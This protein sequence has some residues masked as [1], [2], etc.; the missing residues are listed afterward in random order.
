MSQ[1]MSGIARSSVLVDL[2]ISMY[3][4]RKQDTTTRDEVTASKGAKSKRAASVYKSLFADCKELDDII[5]FQAR[6][7][8]THYKY[9]K[10]WLDSGVRM[11]PATLLQLYQD[12]MY[13][14]EREFDELVSKFLDKYDTLVAAAAFQLGTLFNRSEYPLRSEVRRKFAFHLTYTPMPT[15]G[16]FRLDIENE[17]QAALVEQYEKSMQAMAERAAR[18]SWEKLHEVLSRMARQLA[19]REDGKS[20]KIYDSLLGNAYELCELLKHFNVTGDA[21]M[22]NMR[23]QLMG[24]ME[25]LNTDA[26]RKEADTRAIV[27]KKVQAML[28]QHNW[29]IEDEDDG[30]E[31]NDGSDTSGSDV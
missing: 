26:L 22:E 12:E 2:S 29:G 9:T 8:Q 20:G 25:G 18:D 7:R 28:D 6:L 4:G 19:P 14:R 1:I 21:A 17:T 30:D 23:Q 3:S 16:D 11:L 24:V 10:P 27:H 13:D 31:D 15:S 5:K